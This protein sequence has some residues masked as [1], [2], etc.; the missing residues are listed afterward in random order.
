M[1]QENP[2]GSARS[3]MAA[4]P[5]RAASRADYSRRRRRRFVELAA[6]AALGVLGPVLLSLDAPPALRGPVLAV[7][8]LAGPGL[9]IVPRLQLPGL[10]AVLL[11]PVVSLA[12]V[13]LASLFTI[14]VLGW[15]QI[16]I[17]VLVAA[18]MVLVAALPRQPRT[19][20]TEPGPAPWMRGSAR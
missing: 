16:I 2:S 13:T 11:V 3:A 17:C 5:T 19:L 4:T 12:V 20:P 8:L 18:V 9:A 6:F 14:Y 10:T 15:S 7:L 1:T